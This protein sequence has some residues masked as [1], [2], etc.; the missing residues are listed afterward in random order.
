[1]TTQTPAAT[2]QPD[3][4]AKPS[5]QPRKVPRIK[6]DACAMHHAGY[7]YKTIVVNAPAGLTLSDLNDHPEC[8][9]LI[10]QDRNGFALGEYDIVEIRWP[11]QVVTARVNHADADKVVLFDIRRA[12]KPQRDV[13]LFSDDM[14]EVRWAPEGGYT[15]YRKRDGVKMG[16]T[17]WPTP[18]AAKHALLQREYNPT[19]HYGVS[20]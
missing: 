9:Q 16:N 18:E 1:M 13:A 6:A 14:F 20:A 12:S 19:Q 2:Q 10:Q 15:Y 5:A 17:T 4:T 3:E 8:W 7:C 11:E